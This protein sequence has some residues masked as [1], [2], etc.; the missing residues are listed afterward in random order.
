MGT[1]TS[2]YR[3]FSWKALT[4]HR[5]AC[6]VMVCQLTRNSLPSNNQSMSSFHFCE[7]RTPQSWTSGKMGLYNSQLQQRTKM[8]LADPI[9]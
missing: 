6:Y 2:C 1:S 3:A 9:A 4:M 8:H 5:Y 7:I